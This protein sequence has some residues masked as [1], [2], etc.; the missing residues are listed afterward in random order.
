[1]YVTYVGKL[2]T[3]RR[4]IN[5]KRSFRIVGQISFVLNSRDNGYDPQDNHQLVVMFK[6]IKMIINNINCKKKS[7]K[8]CLVVGKL[9]LQR[10]LKKKKENLRL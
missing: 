1:M 9:V 2:L 3:D 6:N 5:I 7:L 8:I 10:L 4:N